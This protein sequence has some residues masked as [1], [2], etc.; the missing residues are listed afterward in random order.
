MSSEEI[1]HSREQD[2]FIVEEIMANKNS[3]EIGFNPTF[4]TNDID[5][6][7]K[8]LLVYLDDIIIKFEY[9]FRRFQIILSLHIKYISSDNDSEE[10]VIPESSLPKIIHEMSDSHQVIKDIIK[11]FS[12]RTIH[13]F[14]EFDISEIVLARLDIS[15][16]KPVV[17]S[18]GRRQR[19]TG[20][21]LG[22]QK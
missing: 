17:S 18:S 14:D 6:F 8:I 2:D 21:K 1:A 12:D 7:L 9:I 5:S 20:L 13:S 16:F 22:I 3:I 4:K 10:L 15:K 11:E 19:Y